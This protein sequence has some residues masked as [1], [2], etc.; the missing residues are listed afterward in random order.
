MIHWRRDK[1]A[2][3]LSG[4]GARGALQ[5][6][7]LRA[8]LE[9]GIRP[10]LVVG[11]SIGAWNG[12]WLAHRPELEW[13]ERLDEVWRQVSRQSLD[14]VWWR[15]A[16]NMVRR[17]P[18]LYEGSGLARL[19]GLHLRAHNFEDLAVPLHTVAIDL[20]LG[21]KSVFSRGPLAPAVLASSAIPGIFPPVT[22]DD[23]QHVDGGMV[24]PTGLDTA[25]ELG[26]RRIFILDSGYAGQLPAP[27]ASMNAIV[28]HTFQ[29]AAQHRTKWTMQ[30]MGRSIEIVHL[31][32]S[33]G[34]LRHSMDF[35]ATA[36]YLDEGYR[37]TIKELEARRKGR[38]PAPAAAAGAPVYH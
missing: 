7:M 30:Q 24:D 19:I 34:F 10:D 2:F 3:A 17:R 11:V 31:R 4:G 28:D 20:T 36:S 22:I 9:H 26:A 15:A 18:S 37:Y 16:R 6:G 13:I 32:P 38:R 33:A 21:T 12:A 1:T 5:V 35:G 27:L 29:I 8:L 25:I 23:H 14:M